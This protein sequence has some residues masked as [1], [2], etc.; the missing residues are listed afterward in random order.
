MTLC[1][2]YKIYYIKLHN[3]IYYI[4]ILFIIYLFINKNYILLW[5]Y[6][7][8]VCH[9]WLLLQN[10]TQFIIIYNFK[11]VHWYIN[12]KN[13]LIFMHSIKR[14]LIAWRNVFLVLMVF[15]WNVCTQVKLTPRTRSSTSASFLGNLADFCIE[16]SCIY[17]YISSDFWSDERKYELLSGFLTRQTFARSRRIFYKGTYFDCFAS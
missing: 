5:K 3:F 17:I 11:I 8:T 1:I 10:F 15:G 16:F 12:Y 13:R 4:L 9:N 2:I 7:Q 6:A 14:L